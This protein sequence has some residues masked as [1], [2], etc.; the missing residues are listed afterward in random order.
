MKCVFEEDGSATAADLWN[1]ADALYSSE[2]VYPE[3]RAAAAAA[4]R[5]GRIDS[6][7]LRAAVDDIE[8]LC[9]ELTVIGVDAALARDAGELAEA[10]A[11]RGYDAVH[12]ASAISMADPE[13]VVATW[14]SQ[15]GDAA[16][17]VGY[18][19]VPATP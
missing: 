15:L 6:A 10:H 11:L 8:A 14:E 2:L 13:L 18:A 3:A 12:L 4:R 9:D 5:A 16:V 7:R 17:R 19:V 1:R